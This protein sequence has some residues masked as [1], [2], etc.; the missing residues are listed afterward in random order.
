[1]N[2]INVVIKYAKYNEK[3]APSRHTVHK[4]SHILKMCMNH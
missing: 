1:M 3:K 2:T 4:N